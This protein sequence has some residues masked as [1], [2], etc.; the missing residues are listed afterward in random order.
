[1]NQQQH[2]IVDLK[3]GFKCEGILASIDKVNFK[4]NMIKV[5][6]HFT[7]ENGQYFEEMFDSLE[8]PKDDIKE[9][10]LV[11]FEKEEKK[12][13]NAIP[14]NKISSVQSQPT[15]PKAY[16][17][18]DSFFDNLSPMSNTDAKNES[19][20]YNDKNCET[21]NLPANSTN[22]GGNMN[23]GNRN[24]GGYKGGKKNYNN[25][26]Y[27]NYNNN[28]NNNYRGGNRRGRGGYKWDTPNQ[29]FQSYNEGNMNER[30]NDGEERSIYDKF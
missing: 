23:R 29:N 28:Y 5:K 24:R 20:K 9:V 11:Q 14:E 2:V 15:K 26:S 7:D 22:V 19:I 17:K 10:K 8:I 6:K 12:N 3:N 4:I 30:R 25:K 13:I 27:N 1:M 16:S 21:F 18:N